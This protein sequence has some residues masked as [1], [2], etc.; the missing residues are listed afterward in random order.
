[1]AHQIARI[2]WHLTNCHV[3]FDMSTFAALETANQIRRLNRLHA[4][5]RQMGYHSGDNDLFRRSSAPANI[6]EAARNVAPTKMLMKL[7]IIE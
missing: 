2:I 1:M 4:A 6:R 3:L 7:P 5:A